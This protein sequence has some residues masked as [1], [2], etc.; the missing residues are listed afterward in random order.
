MMVTMARMARCADIIYDVYYI[1]ILYIYYIKGYI[2][3]IL[4]LSPTASRAD[5]AMLTG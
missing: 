1:Y 5:L 2:K 4:N 3:I